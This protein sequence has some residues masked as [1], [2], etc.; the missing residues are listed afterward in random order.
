M[1]QNWFVTSNSQI[2]NGKNGVVGKRVL[3]SSTNTS[4]VT[5]SNGLTLASHEVTV[6]NNGMDHVMTHSQRND[7][8]STSVAPR[9]MSLTMAETLVHGSPCSHAPN[10]LSVRTQ[11]VDEQ[12]LK[13]SRLLVPMMP[14]MPRSM[15]ASSLVKL[16]VKTNP[17]RY[18]IPH[19]NALR[20]L[21]GVSLAAKPNLRFNGSRTLTATSNATSASSGSTSNSTPS[22]WK[23]LEKRPTFQTQ[24]RSDFLR[25][26]SRKSSSN[27]ASR[28]LEKSK[29]S[30]ENDISCT[31]S[32]SRDSINKE[33]QCRTKFILSSE[34]EEIAFLR[35]LGWEE[36]N[37]DDECLTEEEIQEF[38]DKYGKLQLFERDGAESDNHVYVC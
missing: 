31:A 33:Q 25:N 14:Y 9:A 15:G 12:A 20:E 22:A 5:V 18:P 17:Q 36:D 3:S 35:S 10:Q 27:D 29:A 32:S 28:V 23:T 24:S 37:Q 4:P 7:S 11:K 6:G 19:S 1:V 26:L 13:K 21:N 30:T 2:T 16:K 8:R 38:Y 34:E